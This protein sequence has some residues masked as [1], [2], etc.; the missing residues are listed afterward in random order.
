MILG[1]APPIASCILSRRVPEVSLPL[2]VPMGSLGSHGP[3][4]RPVSVSRRGLVGAG[5]RAGGSYPAVPRHPPGSRARASRDVQVRWVQCR[6]QPP[7]QPVEE[8]LAP[9][10]G[11]EVPVEQAVQPLEGARLDADPV[12]LAEGP[13]IAALV[14]L[15]RR[16]PGSHRRRPRRWE[17]A[18]AGR[19]G[20]R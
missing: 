10:L 3:S 7:A 19:E 16:A 8:H 1:T 11:G 6:K 17:M 20:S 18:G 13:P 12:T 15:R 4:P 9:F 5:P 14:P 2:P